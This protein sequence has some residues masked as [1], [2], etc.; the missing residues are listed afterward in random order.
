[1]MR[2]LL[3]GAN[4]LM[5]GVF[6][7]SYKHL[8]PQIPIFY[9]HAW[10]EDQLGDLVMLAVFPLLL[11]SLYFVNRFLQQR[12]FAANPLISTIIQYLNL[13][14]VISLPLI[15]LKVILHVS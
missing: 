8:P 7:F 11:D 10:G 13:F 12:F 15:F 14:L 4:L 6:V 3:V 1:M 9:S 5:A 2:L